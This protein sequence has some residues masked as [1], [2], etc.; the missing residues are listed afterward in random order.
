MNG[1]QI[2]T[3][4]VNDSI[5]VQAFIEQ[6]KALKYVVGPEQKDENGNRFIPIHKAG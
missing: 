6:A 4:S 1:P 5:N 3:I 2:G